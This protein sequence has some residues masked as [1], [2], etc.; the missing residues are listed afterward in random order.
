[1]TT[2]ISSTGSPPSREEWLKKYEDRV[3]LIT[4]ISGA[5]N[6]DFA[7]D[8]KFEEGLPLP[9]SS[10]LDSAFKH[11]DVN[12]FRVYLNMTKNK[13]NIF[14]YICQQLGEYNYDADK[15]SF[16]LL[17]VMKVLPEIEPVEFSQYCLRLRSYGKYHSYNANGYWHV[18]QSFN[19]AHSL[20][21]DDLLAN[22]PLNQIERIQPETA[23]LMGITKEKIESVKKEFIPDVPA[24]IVPRQKKRE[25]LLV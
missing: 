14:A 24:S 8:V 2:S 25:C 20:T 10:I 22:L 5:S 11:N 16:F 3:A 19:H 17:D 9:P 7:L 23:I 4:Q 13:N 6:V 12:R 1:M 21:P 18:I 15:Y